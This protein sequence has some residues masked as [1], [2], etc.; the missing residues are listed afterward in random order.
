VVLVIR[1]QWG[2]WAAGAEFHL[3]TQAVSEDVL[4]LLPAI[5]Q[6]GAKLLL[7]RAVKLKSAYEIPVS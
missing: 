5:T 6:T 2:E 1:R 3:R 7:R 4:L